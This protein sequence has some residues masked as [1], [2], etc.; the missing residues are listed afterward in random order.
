[1]K[2]C[3]FGAGAIGGMIGSLLKNVGVDVV[4]I[5]RGEHFE[6]IKKKG[7]IFLSHE[8]NLELCQKF[9][10]YDNIENIGSFDLI[11]NGLKAHSSSENA[12]KISSIMKSNTVFLPTLNGLPWWFFYKIG[13]KYDNFQLKS[14]DPNNYQ[15][16]FINPARVIGS[17]VYPAAEIKEPGVIKHIEGRRFILGEPDNSKS[18]RIIEISKLF[19]KAG[20][21]APISKNIR[22]D[23]WLKLIGNSSFN[24]LSIITKSTL[25]QLCENEN[26]K[27]I[28]KK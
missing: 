22:N 19:M 14:V 2:I 20:M 6:T 24:P 11:I 17:V 15:W 4:L 5:A 28:V 12:K 8:Y 7:L 1:M 10:I 27:L 25:K 16:N 3:I 9:E 18:E 13:G 26:T 21:K 23:I